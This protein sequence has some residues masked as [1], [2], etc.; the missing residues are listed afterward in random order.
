MDT[1]ASGETVY[2]KGAVW[3]DEDGS[4]H[5]TVKEPTDFIVTVNEEEDR[6]NGHPTLYKHLTE[7][8]DEASK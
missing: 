4:I 6:L 1:S 7:M 2:F 8:L 5:L 3:K